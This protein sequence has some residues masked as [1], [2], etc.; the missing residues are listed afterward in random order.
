MSDRKAGSR[1][2]DCERV[3]GGECSTSE[4]GR[5]ELEF[6]SSRRDSLSGSVAWRLRASKPPDQ[7]G[8]SAQPE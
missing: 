4:G 5:A 3:D 8:A 2:T 6:V 1:R 7:E